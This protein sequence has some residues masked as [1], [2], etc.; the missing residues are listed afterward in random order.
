[1]SPRRLSPVAAWPV[2]N[3]L[4]ANITYASLRLFVNLLSK[5]CMN[6]FTKSCSHF[7]ERSIKGIYAIPKLRFVLCLSVCTAGVKNL[8]CFWHYFLVV[9]VFTTVVWQF[10]KAGSHFWLELSV[11]FQ[12]LAVTRWLFVSHFSVVGSHTLVRIVSHFITVGSHTL[13][14]IVSHFV[15]VGSHTLVRTGSHL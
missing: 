13:V 9:S 8:L 7:S 11:T 3:D 12:L 5:F 14:R 4:D 2:K 15:T 6:S 1:M 10:F